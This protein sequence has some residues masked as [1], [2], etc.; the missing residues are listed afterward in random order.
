MGRIAL[1]QMCSGVDPA[2][3]A[4]VIE[5]AIE[6]AAS[7]GATML[8]TPEMSGLLDRDRTRAARLIATEAEDQVLARVRAAAKAAGMWV[9][10]G[11]LALRGEERHANR[12]FVI[13]ADGAV[14]A[15]YDKLHMFDVDLGQED[16]RE[17]SAYAPGN[18]AVVVAT[19]V[20]DV[21]LSICY[22]LRFAGLYASLSDAGAQILAV[23]AAFTVPTG[24]AH[25]HVLLRARAIENGCF[26][27]A[28]AQSG[29]HEDG[30]RTY[31]HSLVVDPWGKV[32][33]DMG[34]AEGLDY[35][36]VDLG[37]VEEARR[38]VPVLSH[39]R[40]LPPVTR[41]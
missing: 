4:A 11:S 25:W 18:I 12:G 36:D 28:A 9:Q 40:P 21:G 6:Q 17:S 23:P 34:T 16:W 20:G 8:F 41:Q 24:G 35:C 10:L 32:V 22:D 39:R 33:L 2:A 38:R 29:E 37:L 13:D 14:R 15:R 5:R 7:D 27:I 30:R 26:V 19:P 31:G 1:L 3:N